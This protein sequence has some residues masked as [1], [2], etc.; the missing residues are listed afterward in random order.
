ME[1]LIAALWSANAAAGY[2]ALD[3]LLEMSRK[4][5]AVYACMDEFFAR[6]GCG[7]SYVRIR[8]LALIVANAPWDAAGHIDRRIGE[9][10]SHLRDPRPVT[11][12]RLIQDLPALVR[13]K[14]ALRGAVLEAL[15]AGAAPFYAP[16]M[17][18]LVAAD[19]E[20]ALRAIEAEA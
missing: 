2:A 12:R 17:R 9:I 18:P 10:L 8:A 6:L 1:R 5:D 20:K 14:P 15:R 19:M 4:S 7:S 3:R 13:A 16:S 11:A